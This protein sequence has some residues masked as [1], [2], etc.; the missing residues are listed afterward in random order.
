MSSEDEEDDQNTLKNSEESI[1]RAR[2]DS[3]PILCHKSDAM[4]DEVNDFGDETMA[5]EH[6]EEKTVKKKKRAMIPS[7]DEEDER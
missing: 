5:R 6:G 4:D 1:L 2:N 7:D 3:E